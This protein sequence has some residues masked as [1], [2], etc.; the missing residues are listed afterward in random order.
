[1]T[2]NDPRIMALIKQFEAMV[3]EAAAKDGS[4]ELSVALYV[5]ARLKVE[6]ET[7]RR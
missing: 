2:R 1:M 3:K 6:V 7:M 4:T 5:I